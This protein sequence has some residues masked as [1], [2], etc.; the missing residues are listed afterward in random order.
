MSTAVEDEDLFSIAAP[1]AVASRPL[2]L[3][4][5]ELHRPLSSYSKGD[6]DDDGGG[7]RAD[8]HYELT[9]GE[10]LERLRLIYSPVQLAIDLDEALAL[11][12]PGL[13]LA[14]FQSETFRCR[15]VE[16]AI[17][18]VGLVLKRLACIDRRMYDIKVYEMDSFMRFMNHPNV[19]SLYT[20]WNEPVAGPYAYKTLVGLYREGVR[21]D[22]YDYAVDRPDGRR[23]RAQRVK[24][25][26]CNI[27]SALRSFH[28]CNLIH[29]GIRPRNIYVDAGRVAMVGEFGKV[30]LDSLRYSHHMFSKLFIANA[31][32]HK[33]AYWAPELI[34]MQQYGKEVD[35][36]ALGVT[37]YQM[38]TGELPWPSE[39]EDAFKQ[40]VI[41][42]SK[43][44]GED[45]L[46]DRP[47]M[48][49][50][51][52]ETIGNLLHPNPL[53]RWTADQTLAYLQFDFA[54]EIQRAWR[55]AVVR[56][57]WFGMRAAIVAFQ[58]QVRG[59]LARQKLN[60]E[61]HFAASARAIAGALDSDAEAQWREQAA[62]GGGGSSSGGG[63]GG[64]G[65][66]AR[67]NED[68][69]EALQ[70]EADVLISEEDL[71]GAGGGGS[72]RSRASSRSGSRAGSRAGGGTATEVVRLQALLQARDVQ[73]NILMKMLAEADATS[74][75][76]RQT[77]AML[78][79]KAAGRNS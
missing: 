50:V 6:N 39:S 3:F 61:S 49:E 19:I 77:I 71:F 42:G 34:T 66:T 78:E 10:I 69:I 45:D 16:E 47:G 9:E 72:G 52:Q 70:A 18:H 20:M 38:V 73:L 32:H 4:E 62:A 31:I 56:T 51:L 5:N 76:H 57:K 53:H 22:L 75:E 37:L 26:G 48:D 67:S 46:L 41:A 25:L 15:P 28:N 40:A 1:S 44:F 35:C 33:L 79:A 29:A 63:G 74:V 58:A 64:G 12:H 2:N 17:A 7:K 8:G 23:L 27:A 24:L 43:G 60:P 11:K 55:G 13:D 30:E 68:A 36:W 65:S 59:A 14:V 54:V 21:G